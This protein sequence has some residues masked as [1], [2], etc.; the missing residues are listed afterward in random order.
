[1]DNYFGWRIIHTAGL[2]ACQYMNIQLMFRR[3]RICRML[4]VAFN[5]IRCIYVYCQKRLK[6]SQTWNKYNYVFKPKTTLT[7][8]F[9]VLA[10]ILVHVH[11]HVQCIS[12][13]QTSVVWF[14]KYPNTFLL[15]F[16]ASLQMDR[17]I[18]HWYAIFEND[19][20]IEKTFKDI[21]TY[22]DVLIWFI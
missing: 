15:V 2:T 7:V 11:V 8:P 20:H 17:N 4:I 5:I 1:M 14:Q 16:L 19:A 6:I 21:N 18:L 13:N 3:S 12:Y 22:A 9:T 10:K